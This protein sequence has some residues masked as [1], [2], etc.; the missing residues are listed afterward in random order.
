MRY[1]YREETPNVWILIAVIWLILMAS[2]TAYAAITL[3]RIRDAIGN[4]R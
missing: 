1:G 3:V 2:I 4:V